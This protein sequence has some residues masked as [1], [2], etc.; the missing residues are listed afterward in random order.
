MTRLRQT[1][2]EA[3]AFI[4]RMPTELAG[5]VFLQG[6]SVVQPDPGHLDRYQTHAGQRRDQW[7]TSPDITEAMFEQA[8][9]TS[10]ADGS[11]PATP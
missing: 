1:L 2:T 5:L 10:S 11:L 4:E 8:A 9:K 7:P 6:A 3:E